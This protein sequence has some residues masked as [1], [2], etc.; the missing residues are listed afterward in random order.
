[1]KIAYLVAAIAMVVAGILN[2]SVG[3]WFIG[4][5]LV[6]VGGLQVWDAVDRIKQKRRMKN[7]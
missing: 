7:G 2:L 6:P 5:I 3:N 4:G 1:M